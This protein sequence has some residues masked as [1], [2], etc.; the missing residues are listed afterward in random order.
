MPFPA[1]TFS[2]FGGQGHAGNPE[3]SFAEIRAV[4]PD[5]LH[6]RGILKAD[7]CHG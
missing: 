1:S 4:W 7:A 3:Y 6:L 5:T 2:T